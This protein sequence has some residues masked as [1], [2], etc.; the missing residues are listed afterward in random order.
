MTRLVIK[1]MM[2]EGI[3]DKAIEDV[4]KKLETN[5]RVREAVKE[6]MTRKNT[7][8]TLKSIQQEL[9]E[10][11]QHQTSRSSVR[12]LL[13]TEGYRWRHLRVI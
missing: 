4:E 6:I 12:K 1:K 7:Y 9:L 3:S 2:K 11:H 13:I 8:I 10:K 5:T